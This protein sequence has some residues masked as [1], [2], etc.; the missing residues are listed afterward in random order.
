M[1]IA[2][3]IKKYEEMYCEIFSTAGDIFHRAENNIMTGDNIKRLRTQAGISQRELASKLGVAKC[4][5]S[6]WEVDRT[7]PNIYMLKQMRNIF[8]CSIEELID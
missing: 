3:D 7:E 1:S 8:G 5:V 6:S 2:D 4:T